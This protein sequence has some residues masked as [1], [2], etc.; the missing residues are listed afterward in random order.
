MKK[1]LRFFCRKIFSLR[2]SHLLVLSKVTFMPLINLV[3]KKIIYSAMVLG[4]N[5]FLLH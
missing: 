1:R 5:N 2:K 4:E 3:I